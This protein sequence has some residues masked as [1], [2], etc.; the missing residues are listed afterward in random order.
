VTLEFSLDN[1]TYQDYYVTFSNELYNVIPGQ[2]ILSAWL[3]V[4]PYAPPANSSLTI[5]LVREPSGTFM[6]TEQLEIQGAQFIGTTGDA[7]NTINMT[8]QNTGTAD[9][10][11][12]KYKLGVSG[13]QQDITDVSVTQGSTYTVV[14]TTGADSLA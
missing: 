13:V 4:E 2:Q 14:V 10:T 3:A 1:A 11:V 8:V 6:A 9:L 5:R 7:A 12:D